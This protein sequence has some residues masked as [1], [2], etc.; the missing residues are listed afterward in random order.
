ML[1]VGAERAGVRGEIDGR[2]AERALQAIVEQIVERRAAACLL[3][4]VDAAVA[5]VVEHDDDELQAEHHRRRDLAIHHQI[6]AVADHHDHLALGPRKLGAESARD[7]V[8]HARVAVFDVIRARTARA[9][10]LVQLGGQRAGGAHDDIVVR[11]M[12][13]RALHGADHV[14]AVGQGGYRLRCSRAV[15]HGPAPG[16]G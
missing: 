1:G 15:R 13:D 10:E 12:R 3:Q 7:F 14:G 6:A 11:G 8:T 4:S 16:V 9:P 5:A 2:C